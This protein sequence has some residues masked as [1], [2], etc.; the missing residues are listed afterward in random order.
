[1]TRRAL[2]PFKLSPALHV[3]VWGGRRLADVMNKSLPTDEPYGE[4]WELHDTAIVNNGPLRGTSL[5][6]LARD[7]G[8]D[9]L[10]AGTDGSAGLPLLIKFIDAADWLSIQVHPNDEQ[11]RELESEP[12]GKTEAWL[13]LH[14]EAGA[15]LVIGPRL[16]TSREQMVEAIQRNQLEALLVY[17]KVETGDVLTI[18]ANTI[19]ALG[20]GIMVYEIQQSSDITYRLYD[21]ARLG[22]DGQP[23]ELHIDKG[24]KVARFDSLPPVRQPKDELLVDGEYFSLWRHKLAGDPLRIETGARF[25]SLTCIAGRLQVRAAGQE[26]IS[27]HQGESGLIPASIPAFALRGA[28]TILRACQ[29]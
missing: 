10:G 18:P 21:W 24:L 17:A 16:G 4:A 12:R 23:R 15:Q 1:M 19:H 9:L 27:L 6:D 7:Y 11:A 5:G 25:Q 8:A 28:G 14:A 13:I 26:A 29:S 2:Y 20:P 22:L 3:K